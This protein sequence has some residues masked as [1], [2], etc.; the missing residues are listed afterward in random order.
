MLIESILLVS[1]F[2]IFLV[3]KVYVLFFSA[4]IIYNFFIFK[5]NKYINN[6]HSFISL[7]KGK[8]FHNWQ[9][10]CLGFLI[11]AI[12]NYLMN[13]SGENMV[14]IQ[15]LIVNLLFLISC[16][17][18]ATN[19]QND[20]LYLRI[21]YLLRII[22]I[23]NLIQI[24]YIYFSTNT[25][26]LYFLEVN[27]SSDAYKIFRDRYIFIGH[28]NK[29]I[30]ATKLVFIQCIYMYFYYERHKLK[31]NIFMFISILNIVLL[32]SRTAQLAFGF[33]IFYVIYDIY[34]N[35]KKHIKIS[36]FIPSI[37]IS[38]LLICFIIYKF[39]HIKFNMEDGGFTRI[40]MWRT[41]IKNF[42]H[43]NFIFGYGIGKTKE[44]LIKYGSVHVN[45]NMHNFILNISL[46]FGILGL[47]LYLMWLLGIL[48]SF[49]YKSCNKIKTILVII[50]PFIVIISLQYLGYDND[51]VLFLGIVY[52]LKNKAYNF[53]KKLT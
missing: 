29:N 11:W 13:F 10:W 4:F 42:L 31:E 21:K 39:F 26:I 48:K 1:I 34:I 2:S 46:E 20:K 8:K 44:F 18:Y 35:L 52:I 47:G 32:L 41:F 33:C 28:D 27:S 6:I 38:A 9:R 50:I 45:T 30:W 51:L 24:L 22:I 17:I 36:I 3:K 15:K 7:K 14:L 37:V 40:I 25:S 53:D 16:G 43:E 5:H 12:I 19:K 49:L 23:C